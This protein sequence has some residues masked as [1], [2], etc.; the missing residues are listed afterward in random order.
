ML[1]DAGRSVGGLVRELGREPAAGG[2]TAS[3]PRVEPGSMSIGSER[4]V[5]A[6][7]GGSKWPAAA[8]LLA[9]RHIPALDGWRGVAIA[10]VMLYHLWPRRHYRVAT[11]ASFGW[12]GVDLFFVLSGFLI[13]RILLAARE[14]PHYFRNFYA[15]RTL[16]IFPLYYA[17]VLAV[18]VA[19]PVWGP[20]HERVRVV[21]PHAAVALAYLTNLWQA[22]TGTWYQVPAPFNVGHF[23][24]LAVEEQFYLVW[25]VAVLA[26]AGP[27]RLL[28]A[29]GACVGISLACRLAL[30]TRG[31]PEMV[32]FVLTPCRLDGL[33]LGAALAVVSTRPD[34]WA[35]ARKVARVTL[36]VT[37]AAVVGMAV[38][39][40]TL[41]YAGDR[42]IGTAGVAISAPLCAAALFLTVTAAQ[43]GRAD[44]VLSAAPLR[45]LGRYS[46]GLYVY[47]GL[48]GGFL[49]VHVGAFMW[50]HVPW[51][52]AADAAYF[53]AVAAACT[54][55][56]VVSFHGF[57][58]PILRLK[59]FFPEPATTVPSPR[60][61]S[62]ARPRLAA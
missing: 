43:G 59:R 48:L 50:H 8:P 46:Y 6:N 39:E 7:V 29:C 26:I 35:A 28:A 2:A 54:A 53:L 20:A 62:N 17:V 41:E 25:P 10:A 11:V 31:G 56:A 21:G 58:Q 24:S 34:W 40:R 12:M 30:W 16:R 19:W 47:H 55:I 57:E 33:G 38:R 4:A 22:Y 42:L 9:A 61:P 18:A 32:P 5:G 23:W 51:G 13:T 15:R 36:G 60:V 3:G 45:W 49:Q 1:I 52:P 14:R 37:L 27:K 44:R